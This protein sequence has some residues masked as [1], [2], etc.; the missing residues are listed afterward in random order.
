MKPVVI[1]AQTPAVADEMGRRLFQPAVHWRSP[2]FASDLAGI[3]PGGCYVLTPGWENN[4]QGH[5]MLRYL[6]R[7]LFRQFYP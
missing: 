1:L 2:L 7:R 4:P 3:R 6:Q 5:E